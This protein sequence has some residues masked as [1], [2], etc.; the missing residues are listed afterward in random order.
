MA[1]SLPNYSYSQDG[2]LPDDGKSIR[3]IHIE[4][5]DL[6]SPIR[7][8][9]Q[10]HSL[11]ELDLR[12]NALSYVWGDESNKKQIICDAMALSITSNL[13]VALH[14]LR[15]LSCGKIALEKASVNF[16]FIRSDISPIWVDAI[17]IYPFQQHSCRCFRRHP[18][19]F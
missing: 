18:L 5:G 9:L 13:H 15:E 6:D 11:D 10:R 8:R 19:A 12:Y 3:L 7:V 14:Q 16:H 4:R 2:P 17:R 1:E